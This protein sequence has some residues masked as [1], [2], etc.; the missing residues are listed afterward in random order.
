LRSISEPTKDY[1]MTSSIAA[2]KATCRGKQG[3][4]G[5]EIAGTRKK[6]EVTGRD[7]GI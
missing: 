2:L 3:N 4:P 6:N 7:A 1:E 5:K